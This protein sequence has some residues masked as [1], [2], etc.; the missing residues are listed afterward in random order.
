[1]PKS[2]KTATSSG[3]T[4]T[5]TDIL[6]DSSESS[7]TPRSVSLTLILK[8]TPSGSEEHN[9]LAYFNGILILSGKWHNDEVLESES[10]PLINLKEP[11]FQTMIAN[12]PLILL[13]RALGGKPA[14]DPDPLNHPDNRAGACIDLFP[15]LIGEQKILITA[16][17]VSVQTGER[18][19]CSVIVRA[20]SLGKM[21]DKQVPLVLTMISVHC[22]PVAKDNTFYISAIGLNEVH[23]P[24]AI[25]FNLSLSSANAE[26]IVFAAVSTAGNAANTAMNVHTKDKF[27]PNDLQLQDTEQ[28]RSFYWNAIRRVLVDPESLRE[29]LSSPFMI[30]V[31]GVPRT[32]KIDVRGRYMGV[33]DA[34][35][36]LEPGQIGVTVCSKLVQYNEANT[37]DNIG[38]LLD[39]PPMSA[40]ASARDTDPSVVDEFG[41]TA[42][43]VIRLDLT[44]AIIPKSKLENLYEIMGFL[45]PE[46]TDIP[47]KK[48][49]SD[50]VQDDLGIDAR[51][52]RKEGGALAV[53]KELSGLACKGMIPMNQGIKR[54]AANRL[55]MRV[56]SLLKNFPP[57][58]CSYLDYQDTVTGQHAAS[59]RAVTA[60]FAPQTPAPRLPSIAAAARC[61][62]AGDTRIADIHLETCFKVP[63]YYA[64][65][66]ISKV[67]RL[68]E[69]GN[70]D[71]AKNHLYEALD[72]LPRNRYLLWIFGGLEFDRK[73]F[74]YVAG[75]A[76]RIA[77]KGEYSDGTANSIGWA[78]LH[79]FH[80]YN[81]NI[82]AA[83]VAAMKMRKNFALPVE[84]DQI[85]VRWTEANG[86]EEIYWIP[87]T[88]SSD[89]PFLIAA[90]FFLCL[91]CYRFSEKL[92]QCVEN[93]CASRGSNSIKYQVC[94]DVYYLR[95]ASLI[96]RHDY[97]HAME[98]IIKAI[99][100]FGPTP[101]MSQM[102]ATCL[103]R[104]RNWD[105]DCDKALLEAERAGSDL[106]SSLLYSAAL[107][108]FKL[109]PMAALQRAARA[110]KQNP[111]GHTALLIGRIY[112]A[113][114]KQWFAERWI[115]AAVNTEPLLADG[116][117]ML[118][119]L[120]MYE[121]NIDKA[122]VMLRT[123]RQAGPV[124]PDIEIEV[125]KVMEMVEVDRLPDF[126]V[127]HLCFCDH[128]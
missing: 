118:A 92:L 125:S 106:C 60:S 13:L 85:I 88:V 114:D 116:W 57:G 24:I 127:K 19:N 12:T 100:K 95:A 71:D 113:L 30:E 94:P 46:K 23:N 55:L 42:Y 26:K 107:S 14:K 81:G 120:A 67:L 126:L 18:T 45:L 69:D 93:G 40:K 52:I 74:S 54:T 21:D 39:L 51:T 38:P 75:A 33:V 122:R 111:S 29:R 16:P 56:R 11:I 73:E 37:P 48:S 7:P 58:D 76:L 4:D 123:A 59:R 102:R 65:A 104:I 77:V 41:H 103:A 3:T 36:L 90:A 2:Q 20:I 8:G 91:R 1:M 117:A 62:I 109:D 86:E 84:W 49:R 34:R 35:V 9:L 97:N 115:S 31:A 27:V 87:E 98:M 32:G 105:N 43:A 119:L 128:D 6:A 79:T 121:R 64:T 96:L 72:S 99:N 68:L 108:D 53:H 28:C 101:K 50:S 80:H 82:Y 70:E 112:V 17:L 63:E 5:Q 22:L 124:S 110:H 44:E 66:L 15:L 61:R 89:N 25:N 47:L 83:F 78:A 10:L